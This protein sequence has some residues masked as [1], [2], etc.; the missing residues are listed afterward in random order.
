MKTIN[1]QYEKNP[2]RGDF[3]MHGNKQ[4]FVIFM[5]LIFISATA[6]AKPEITLSVTSEKEIVVMDQGKKNVKRVTAKEVEPGQVLIFTLRYSNK[7]DEA[8]TNVVFDNPI[9][10]E[11]IYKIGSA[12]G[13]GSNIT[14]SINGGKDY[15]KPTLLTYEVKGSDGKTV[16]KKASP[17]QY[18]N[19]RWVIPSVPAGSNGELSFRA[20]VK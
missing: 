17:D 3:I 10:K 16:K 14:F 7:G 9:P 8:A 15:K 6:W 12:A 11:T 5:V 19:V 13:S 18:T 4:R 20:M 2:S 1:N